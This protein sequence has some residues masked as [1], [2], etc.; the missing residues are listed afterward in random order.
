MRVQSRER[1]SLVYEILGDTSL[2]SLVLKVSASRDSKSFNRERRKKGDHSSCIEGERKRLLK[3]KGN[4]S[5]RE[6]C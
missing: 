1:E 4:E 5:A 6:D 2:K 3:R